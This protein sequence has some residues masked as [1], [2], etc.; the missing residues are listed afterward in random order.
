MSDFDWSRFKRSIFIQAD[1]A[2]VFQAWTTPEQVATWFLEEA[3]YTAPDGTER[4]PDETIQ[5]GD[6]Y[7]WKWWNYPHTEQ[8]TITRLDRDKRHMEFTFASDKCTCTVD[9]E[10]R[11]GDTLLRLEQSGMPTDDET[12]KNLH[13]GCSNGWSFWMVNLKS[14]LENDQLLHDRQSRHKT[15]EFEFCELIN[16]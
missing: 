7:T 12:K 14:W 4:R 2:R 16:R 10:V 6:S 9:V 15:E 1:P 8:G 5:E 11:E 3:R 13:L